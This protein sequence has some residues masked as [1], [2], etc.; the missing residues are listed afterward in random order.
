MNSP[1]E[2]P[3]G[4]PQEPETDQLAKKH[5]LGFG[6][7]MRAYFLAGILVIAPIFIT[8]YQFFL[9]GLIFYHKQIISRKICCAVL[10]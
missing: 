8:F 3:S 2:L 5:V 6:Q 4:E 10:K 9:S 1:N 7:R